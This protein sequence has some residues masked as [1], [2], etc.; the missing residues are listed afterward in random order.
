M[1]G[2]LDCSLGRRTASG[3]EIP[4]RGGD[5]RHDRPQAASRPRGAA[6]GRL[7][8]AWPARARRPHPAARPLQRLRSAA[9][10]AHR[11]D[12][13]R[14][15]PALRTLARAGRAP[16]RGALPHHRPAGAEEGDPRPRPGLGRG[17]ADQHDRAEPERRGEPRRAARVH[18]RP[19]PAG[20][21]LPALHAVPGEPD[22]RR[23]APPGERRALRRHHSP[24]DPEAQ[25]DG[26]PVMDLAVRS[27][28]IFFFVFLLMRIVGRR[29][30]SSLEPFDLILLVVL[31]DSVQQ[32]VTQDDY[33]VTGA[34][35]VVSTIAL[36]QVFLSYLNFR[37]PRLRPIIDGEPIVI[38]QD[39]NVIEGNARRERL[40]H[41]DIAEAAR[42]QQIASLEDVQ[43]AVLETSGELT[44]IEKQ[45]N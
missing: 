28:V 2:A 29:E 34:F 17:P 13:R 35:I 21:E 27:A 4:S 30:L 24:P 12:L 1:P 22:E 32:A 19:H 26:V 11:R 40:T 42:L 43:W 16:L 37:V 25:A 14:S 6:Q 45:K 23:V 7:V 8:P 15:A 10:Q 38:V 33:S 31:G 9:G 3:A 5:P 36:L 39:G 18:A 41:E 44:F 20:A